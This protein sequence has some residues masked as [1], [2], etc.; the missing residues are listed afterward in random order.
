MDPLTSRTAFVRVVDSGGFAAPRVPLAGASKP[1]FG[2]NG[3]DLSRQEY[4][5]IRFCSS[6][7]WRTSMSMKVLTLAD[8]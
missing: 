2:Q 1:V 7:L 5:L 8:R 3:P 4:G 6:A